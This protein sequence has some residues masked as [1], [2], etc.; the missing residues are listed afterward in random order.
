[1]RI[2]LLADAFLGI[3]FLVF[4]SCAETPIVTEDTA[5]A[6]KNVSALTHRPSMYLLPGILFSQ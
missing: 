2:K 4:Q 6:Q 1:M 3:A 5:A